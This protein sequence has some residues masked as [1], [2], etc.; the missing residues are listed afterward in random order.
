MNRAGI[1]LAGGAG[2]RLMPLT[3]SISKQLLPV[4]DKPMIYYSLWALRAAGC[5]N[6]A[7]ITTPAAIDQFFALLQ[8]GHDLGCQLTY[9]PQPKPEGIAQAL[10]IA[11]SWLG[12]RECLLALGDNILAGDAVRQSLKEMSRSV[13]HAGIFSVAVA[14]PE[15][16][17]VVS[18]AA[19][20][21]WE[22]EEKPQVPKTDQAIPGYYFLDNRAVEIAKSLKPSGRGELEIVDVLKTYAAADQLEVHKLPTGTAWFDCGTHESL[23]EAGQFVHTLLKRQGL[24]VC[25]PYEFSPSRSAA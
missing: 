2:T 5:D 20:G 25:D 4:Y 6:I 3:K 9:L 19:D 1:L 16:Y 12:D 21:L 15:R 11:E 8:Q 13:V 10:M 7:I 18:V 14:D 17:G 24:T 23:L 22:L